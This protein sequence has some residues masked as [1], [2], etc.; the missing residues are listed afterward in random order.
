MKSADDSKIKKTSLDNSLFDSIGDV[1]NSLT[2]E[3]IS[4]SVETL[5]KIGPYLP[6]PYVEKVNSLVFN[7]EKMSKVNELVSFISKKTPKP[8]DVSTQDISSKERFNKILLTLKDDMP[9]E[10]IKNI[11]PI[12]DIVAN[13]DK[14]KSMIGMISAM[15]SPSEKSED[16]MDSMIKMVMPLLGQ[17]EES[18][19]KMKDMMQIFKTIASSSSDDTSENSKSGN[20]E[21]EHNN[22]YEEI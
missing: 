10:K 14:Y 8:S 3:D 19:D 18:N 7:F 5:E 2:L 16:K 11:R 6:E 15:N 9:E 4:K 13:F 1:V 20:Y 21:D 12:I 17:N 22:E